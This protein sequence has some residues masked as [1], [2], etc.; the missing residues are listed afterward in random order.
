MARSDTN[1]K[2]QTFPVTAPDAI[3]LMLA[4]D[5]TQWQEKAIPMQMLA[6]GYGMGEPIPSDYR[7]HHRYTAKFPLE[8]MSTINI[9]HN[10]KH[11]QNKN[12]ETNIK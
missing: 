6:G 7:T 8:V 10:K 2:H 5:F 9:E 3:S 4:G 11:K 1:T 12:Y